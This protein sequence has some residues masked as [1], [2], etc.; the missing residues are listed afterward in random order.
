MNNYP[1]GSENKDSAWYSQEEKEIPINVTVTLNKIYKIK[2]S[3][4][5]IN[6]YGKDEDGEYF[7]DID[8]S[9]CDLSGLRRQVVSTFLL[10]GWDINDINFEV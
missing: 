9:E 7:E 4:Y 6:D 8:Y 1:E 5:K 3:D 2:V 10:D